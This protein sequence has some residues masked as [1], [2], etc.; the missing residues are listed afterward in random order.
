M[1]NYS[2]VS[3]VEKLNNRCAL[4]SR[5]TFRLAQRLAA[6]FRESVSACILL[7]ALGTFDA[8][9]RPDCDATPDIPACGGND[10]GSGGNPGGGGNSGAT[11]SEGGLYREA[12]ALEVYLIRG[13]SKVLIPTQDALF[14]MG[15]KSSNVQVVP[16]GKL[17][18]YSKITIPSSSPTP[19]SLIFP[20]NGTKLIPLTATSRAMSLFSQ[21]KRM[22]I[23]EVFGWLW[24][25]DTEDGGCKGDE[26]D[27]AD[28][29]LNL[30]LDTEW[31]LTNGFDL[32]KILRIGNIAA[33][34][35]QQPG[36]TPRKSVSIPLI[37]V[38]LNS[39]GW[40]NRYPP[41]GGKPADWTHKQTDCKDVA[42]PFDPSQPEKAKPRIT[43]ENGKRG[44]YVRMSG[45]LVTDSPH[46]VQSRPNTWFCRNFAICD[47]AK[48]EW[49]GSV[50][51][52]AP[53]PGA[54]SEESD[55]TARWTEMHPPDLIEVID[56]R[57]PSVTVRG[58][59]LAARVAATPGPIF[60]SCEKQEFDIY[61]EASRP[62]NKVARYEELRASYPA[63]FFPWGENADNGSWIQVL[64]D[65]I[66][67]KAKVCG[68]AL[69]GS[70]GRF[71]A[72]YRVW[73]GDPTPPSPRPACPRGKKCCGSERNGACDGQCQPE[74][75]E[76]N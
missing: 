49:E 38:E 21:G 54:S 65:H 33:Q 43:L 59:A 48:A 1:E 60:P 17:R 41:G 37:N 72:I 36:S 28:F 12:G 2:E 10:G 18:P 75:Q 73:W 62:A 9:A 6:G 27:G 13:R 25:S 23:T 31:A 4:I 64:D 40:E 76:C 50:Q 63:V 70:P 53:R 44:P 67:V 11:I 61:P 20:P 45:S 19:G 34:G 29:H 74:N 69:G 32:H 51:D 68:G 24:K 46:D 22:Q 47:S 5:V 35:V 15:Y 14:A 39:W 7:A 66:R 3:I 42:W 30:E 55:H 52:W 57:E 8:V 71:K 16:D 58:L 56:R 26:G